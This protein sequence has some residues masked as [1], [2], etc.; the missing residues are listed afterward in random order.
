[1]VPAKGPVQFA[2]PDDEE[3]EGKVAGISDNCIGTLAKFCSWLTASP[4]RD[5]VTGHAAKSFL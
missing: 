2:R 3:L 4:C 1:M 5:N